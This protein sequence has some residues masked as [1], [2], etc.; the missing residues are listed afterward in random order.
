MTDSVVCTGLLRSRKRCQGHGS[1]DKVLA[2][3]ARG[4]PGLDPQHLVKLG[5]EAC[6]CY[7]S[8]STVR[9]EVETAGQVA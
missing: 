7:P 2:T 5:A 1:M 6:V 8:L 9:Q 4:I 3:Q